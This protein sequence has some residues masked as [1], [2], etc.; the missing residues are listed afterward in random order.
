MPRKKRRS[1]L[2]KRVI[3]TQDRP[4][5]V[6]R[7]IAK[8]NPY[9]RFVL[10]QLRK[11]QETTGLARQQIMFLTSRKVRPTLYH[12]GTSDN[13]NKLNKRRGKRAE[14]EVMH[15]IRELGFDAVRVPLSGAGGMRGDVL[16]KLPDGNQLMVEVKFS[17]QFT[18]TNEKC[19]RLAMD[20]QS[21][22]E[23]NYH[24]MRSYN[25]IAALF[26]IRFVF[27]RIAFIVIEET[28]LKRLEQ[29][30]GMRF[31]EYVHPLHQKPY[32]EL[33]KPRDTGGRTV[34]I[35]ALA[36]LEGSIYYHSDTKYQRELV[37]YA[38]PAEHLFGWLR[39]GY[40]RKGLWYDYEIKP[41]LDNPA[42]RNKTITA[43]ASGVDDHEE[44][45]D[46]DC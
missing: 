16:V 26:A 30:V 36:A 40:E 10:G 32:I 46:D 34:T 14:Y 6:H 31:R 37:Y 17:S 42:T 39:Q 38:M 1:I 11:A 12:M 24:A 28:H 25:V 13:I 2:P 15:A 20:W 29:L 35:R 33:M 5:P 27:S 3:K 18:K 44:Q 41:R 9:R 19:I 4:L 8:S 21:T 7:R 23:E 45:C 22:I 43:T